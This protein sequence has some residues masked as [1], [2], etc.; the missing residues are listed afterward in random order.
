MADKPL[1]I[2]NDTL[3]RVDKLTNA[4]DGTVVNNATVN[5]TVYEVNKSTV[6]AGPITLTYVG[7]SQGRYDG[8]LP[9]STALVDKQTYWIK[10]M[11][12]APM[13]SE[14]WEKYK[15]TQR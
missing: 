8:T 3:L 4:A 9:A 15:A 12:S 1:Y 14:W 11:V 2:K 6:T 10:Y 7:A 5:A 13:V